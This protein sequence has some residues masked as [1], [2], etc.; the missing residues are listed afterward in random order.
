MRSRS[1]A[2]EE[3]GGAAARQK[4]RGPGGGSDGDNDL[5]RELQEEIERLK[6][7]L[8]AKEREIAELAA[9]SDAAAASVERFDIESYSDFSA[10]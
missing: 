3:H 2:E 9:A 8:E 6:A 10:K 4:T 1:A 5:L 7:L